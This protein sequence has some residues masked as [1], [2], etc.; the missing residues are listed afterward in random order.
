MERVE[1]E[2]QVRKALEVIEQLAALL[3]DG[4]QG[5]TRLTEWAGWVEATAREYKAVP[6]AGAQAQWVGRAVAGSR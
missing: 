6:L 2:A 5:D 1:Q 4:V 3:R